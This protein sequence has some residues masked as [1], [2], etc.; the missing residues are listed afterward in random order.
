MCLYLIRLE[1]QA[2]TLLQSW[3][4]LT[5]RRS[6]FSSQF[7]QQNFA[8]CCSESPSNGRADLPAKSCIL[9]DV[10]RAHTHYKG[11]AC[12]LFTN[13]IFFKWANQNLLV[14]V[15]VFN[16][17]CF[18][19]S[20]NGHYPLTAV[21]SKTLQSWSPTSIWSIERNFF[22][23]WNSSFTKSHPVHRQAFQLR[24]TSELPLTCFICFHCIKA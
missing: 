17:C 22:I 21:V 10:Q 15:V 14:T 16:T 7:L 19:S 18:A 1:V 4:Y 24:I 12:F 9:G 11:H 13:L 23:C 5:G 6:H 3:H 2:S 8:A 20:W